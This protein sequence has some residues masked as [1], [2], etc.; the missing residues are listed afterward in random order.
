MMRAG[1]SLPDTLSPAALARVAV[2]FVVLLGAVAVVGALLREPIHTFATTLLADLGS[3]GLF[4]ALYVTDPM[5]GLGFQPV[6]FLAYTGGASALGV[7]LCAWG[8]SM[9]ASVTVYAVGRVFQGRPALV[10]L[11][12]RWR[13]GHWIQAYGARAIAVAAVAPVPFAVA[14]F[15]AGVMGLPLKDLLIGASARGL[16]MGFT[17][18]A[19]IAGWGV[20]A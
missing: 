18:G 2:G 12:L 7:L 13:I 9:C 20:G 1:L 3:V 8:A 4:L 6:M 19:I 11:L 16:K 17:L 15:G 10:A 14:T 5:P